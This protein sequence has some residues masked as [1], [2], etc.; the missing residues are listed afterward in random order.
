MNNKTTLYRG[1]SDYSKYEII[2]GVY[3]GRQARVLYGN[4]STPQS[5][6][7]LD[8]EPELLF[9]YNQRFLEICLSIAPKRVLVIGGGVCMLPRALLTQFPALVVDVVEI[10]PLLPQLA[11]QY[12]DLP[13]DDRFTIYIDDG[14]TFIEQTKAS[15]D[16]I[17]IDA[18]SGFTIPPQLIDPDAVKLYKKAL[19][20]NGVIMLN[21]ISEYQSIHP[22][23]AHTITENFMSYFSHVV[24]Y[25][26]EYDRSTSDEQNLILTATSSEAKFDYLQSQP[27]ILSPPLANFDSTRKI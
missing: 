5:G 7:A 24:N 14:R 15:Y 19:S 23:L 10:D 26:A 9:S 6:I 27:V 25:Q 12:F 21:Y 20:K 4:D 1:I 16:A 18:F 17:I 22:A 8:D 13:T 3:D 2:E 11:A